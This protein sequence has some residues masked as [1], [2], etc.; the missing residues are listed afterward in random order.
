M[1]VNGS[2]TEGVQGVFNVMHIS[3]LTH[4]ST[5]SRVWTR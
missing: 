5:V 3:C 1:Q 2:I 4:F